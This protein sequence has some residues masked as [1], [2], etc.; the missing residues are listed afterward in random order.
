MAFSI[1]VDCT[2]WPLVDGETWRCV[3]RAFDHGRPAI[4]RC[5]RGVIK[6]R[7]GDALDESRCFVW[8]DRYQGFHVEPWGP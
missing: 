6:G 3:Y 2:A 1:V 5:Y 7:G 8:R 4:V